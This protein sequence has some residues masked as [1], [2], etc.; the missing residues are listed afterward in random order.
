[1]SYPLEDQLQKANYAQGQAG[2]ICPSPMKII[3]NVR[4][5]LEK[6]K[7]DVQDKTELLKLLEANPEIE[8]VLTLLQKNNY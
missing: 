5:Q 3:D 4:Y 8:R 7:K 2:L 6:C 1:M